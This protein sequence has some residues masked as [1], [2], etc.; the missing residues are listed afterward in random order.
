MVGVAGIGF[1]FLRLWN[2]VTIPSLLALDAPHM[3]C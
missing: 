3:K 1:A 2:P